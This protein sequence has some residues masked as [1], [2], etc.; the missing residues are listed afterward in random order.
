MGVNVCLYRRTGETDKRYCGW[1]QQDMVFHKVKEV[2]GWDWL[3]YAGDRALH[4]LFGDDPPTIWLNE[5]SYATRP[6]DIDVALEAALAWGYNEDRWQQLFGILKDDPEVYV[7][8]S[9]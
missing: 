2:E 1:R 8:F 6:T 7:Y 5:E 9:Y 4:T 3:R